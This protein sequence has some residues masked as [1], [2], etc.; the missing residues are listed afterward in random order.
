MAW[1]TFAEIL[2]EF[3]QEVTKK[4]F[5]PRFGDSAG[6]WYQTA[7][8]NGGITIV[9]QSCFVSR[10]QKTSQRTSLGFLNNSGIENFVQKG[11]C[12]DFRW[13]IFCLTVQ[14]LFAEWTSWCLQVLACASYELPLHASKCYA[15]EN[16]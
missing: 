3:S 13:K 1:K 9:R 10:Y 6:F 11:R 14:K 4:F 15:G 7:M 12:H 8:R 5:S 16:Y 2:R